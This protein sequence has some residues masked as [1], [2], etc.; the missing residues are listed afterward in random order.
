MGSGRNRFLFLAPQGDTPGQFGKRRR[1]GDA[2]MRASRRPAKR[3]IPL[4]ARTAV[5]VPFIARSSGALAAGPSPW[6]ECSPWYC[7]CFLGHSQCHPD[8]VHVFQYS[9]GTLLLSLPEP[10]PSA[11]VWSLVWTSSVIDQSSSALLVHVSV[12]TTLQQQLDEPEL[13]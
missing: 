11:S 13:L 5:G 10:D 12:E 4:T 7:T 1:R 3:E 9:L 8:S 2:R 6:R